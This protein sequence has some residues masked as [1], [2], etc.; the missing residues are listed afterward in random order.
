MEWMDEAAALAGMRFSQ[1]KV[2]TGTVDS[3]VFYRGAV[4]GDVILI[5]AQ[6]TYIT[7]STMEIRVR[8]HVQH[9]DGT[10]ELINKAYFVMV[11][12]P[13]KETGERK[14]MPEFI[15]ETEEEKLEWE[16]GMIR[17]QLRRERRKENI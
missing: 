8:V 2:V 15:P 12:V 1:S 6:V 14:P 9:L 11:L 17:D 16:N 7:A 10:K 5:C 4:I 3:L 13:D